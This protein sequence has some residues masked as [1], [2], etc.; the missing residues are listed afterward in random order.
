MILS[1]HYRTAQSDVSESAKKRQRKVEG[2]FTLH[3]SSQDYQSLLLITVEL[4]V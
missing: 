2:T 4:K 1:E 3:P